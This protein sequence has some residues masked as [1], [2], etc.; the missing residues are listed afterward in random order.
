MKRL[1]VAGLIAGSWSS[2]VLA[3]DLGTYRPRPYEPEYE[4]PVRDM[5]YSWHGFYM[6]ANAGYGWGNDDTVSLSGPG[7][8]GAIGAFNGEGW[9]GGG[10]VGYNVQFDRLVLGVEADIQASDIGDS[11]SGVSGIYA[12]QASYDIDWF[13][14]IRGRLGYAAG[15]ALLYVTGGVAFADVSYSVAATDGINSVAMSKSEIETGYTVGGGLEYA[16]DEDWSLKTEYLYVDLGDQTV[17][18]PG[19]A[20][21][22]RTV[23]DFHTVRAGLNFRF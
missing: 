3:A 1:L 23:T 17:T 13:S 18:S 12:G 8:G 10:Q 19:G 7:A 11:T 6:G 16:L 15:P 21:S 5:P 20:F 4:E 9:F 22:S 2:C 14:T